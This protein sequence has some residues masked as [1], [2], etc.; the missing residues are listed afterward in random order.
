M[1]MRCE[2]L[3][4]QTTY[5]MGNVKMVNDSLFLLNPNHSMFTNAAS[6]V[7]PFLPRPAP[8]LPPSLPPRGGQRKGVERG[9]IL[10]I[11]RLRVTLTLNGKREI[12]PHDQVFIC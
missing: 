6:R 9:K 5:N 10:G 7:S 4:G 12:V 1:V 8:S 11:E 3:R 2:I